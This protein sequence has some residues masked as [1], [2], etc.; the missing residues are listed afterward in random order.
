MPLYLEPTFEPE[1][2][3]PPGKGVMTS[4]TSAMAST[5]ASAVSQQAGAVVAEDEQVAAADRVGGD[6]ASSPR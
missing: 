2:T 1:R 6:A 3:M 4:A 5:A